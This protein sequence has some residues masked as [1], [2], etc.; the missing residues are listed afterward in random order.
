MELD[1]GHKMADDE[2]Q[3]LERKL[4]RE[5]KKAYQEA[6][7]KA[8]EYLKKFQEEDKKRKKL[9]D[10]GEMTEKDYQKWRQDKMMM[11]KRWESLK[12]SLSEEMNE[13]SRYANGEIYQHSANV[14]AENYNFGQYEIAARIRGGG[15]AD[16]SLNASFTLYD[17]NTVLNLAKNKPD[18]L[19]KPGKKT[20][21]AIAQK[22][23]KKWR[24]QTLQSVMMQGILQ[25]LPI[26]DIA[27][28][29]ASSLAIKDMNV[30]IRTARTMTTSA[31]NAG[32][33][34]GY[35]HADNLGIKVNK[36]WIATLDSRTRH[37][38]RQL[39][40]VS[41]PKEEKFENGLEF[42]AD[43][44]GAPAE[45]YNCRCTLIADFPKYRTNARDMSLR[46]TDRMQEDDYQKWK[47]ANMKQTNVEDLP[48]NPHQPLEKRMADIDDEI[49][50]WQKFSDES[51][52]FSDW[53]RAE[54]EIEKL[55][56]EK[57]NVAKKLEEQIEKK[58]KEDVVTRMKENGFFDDGTHFIA[59]L[60]TSD[61]SADNLEEIEHAF[62]S[63]FS[64]FPQLK[65]KFA[66]IDDWDRRN[67]LDAMA[68][69]SPYGGL[70]SFNPA[71]WR[72]KSITTK[73]QQLF[74]KG[75]LSTGSPYGSAIHE[76]GHAIDS[77]LG[78]RWD[79]KGLDVL[80]KSKPKMASRK[81]MNQVYKKAGIDKSDVSKYLSKYGTYSDEEAFAECFAAWM[82]GSKDNELIKAFGD[83]FEDIMKGVK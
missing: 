37:S 25:G 48:K 57:T 41:I 76:I 52:N 74:K 60:V 14:F 43:P 12:N 22:K 66:G 82:T 49:A 1:Y 16:I 65:G 6:K 63:I 23:I 30:A 24:N 5:Y 36:M 35:K 68:A 70:I 2:L 39:D 9:V 46:N 47:T 69:T 15:T 27:D 18:L 79:E 83:V 13:V 21:E 71:Y 33:L 40:G 75:F 42:P 81:I 73:T 34:E 7:K 38:H 3:K 20:S 17:K 78:N 31:E 29:L 62:D 54:E 19:P 72:N 58:R 51:P 61:L 53:V 59:Q 10:D 32:R 28:R 77:L 44:E 50:K 26:P 8:E 11:N 56:K 80:Y 67:P 4:K 45:V 64:K 55:K